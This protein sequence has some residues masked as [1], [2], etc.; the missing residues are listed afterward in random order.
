MSLAIKFKDLIIYEDDTVLAI[1]KPAYVSSLHERNDAE[2]ISIIDLAKKNMESPIL[3]HRLDRETSGV[4]LIAKNTDS[5]KHIT[6]QFEKRTIQKV[7]H[8]VTQASV[9]IQDLVI[10]I[11]L[12]TDS[13]RRVQ[14]S[15]KEGKPSLTE[16]NTLKQYRHFTLLECLPHTGR[17][18]QIRIHAAS[19]N[20]PL[21]SD[22]LYGGKIAYLDAIKRKV[23]LGK[24]EENKP[25][26]K[27]VALHAFSIEFD[28]LEKGRVKIEAP[29]PKDFKVLIHLLEKYD[30]MGDG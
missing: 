5:Y 28:S 29:Y 20:L 27:R 9:N 19:Q 23:K 3:C 21:V 24:D 13:K 11:P 22:E 15:R 14:L 26:I 16:I 30:G 1:N 17:L 6:L 8:A 18:H 25:L 4:M 12:L 10:D 7:Y 2:A